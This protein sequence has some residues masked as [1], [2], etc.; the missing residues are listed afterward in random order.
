MIGSFIHKI[1][2]YLLRLAVVMAMLIISRAG[3]AQDD[4][5]I[6][7]VKDGNMFIWL[8]KKLPPA[9]LDAFIVKFDLGH[10]ALK[11]FIESG[12]T[13]SIKLA[14]WVVGLNNSSSF[15][16]AKPL[17]SFDGINDPAKRITFMGLEPPLDLQFPSVSNSVL[18]GYNKFRNKDPFAIKDSVVTFYLR[19]NRKAEKVMLA[20]SFNNWDPSAMSMTKTDSGWIAGVTLK[21]GK[22]WYKFIVDGKWMTDPDNGYTEN[23]YAGNTNSVYFFTNT[24]FRLAGYT[25]AKKVFVAGSFNG[26]QGYQLAM[27]K[28]ANSWELP[29]YLADGTHTYR[30]VVDGKWMTDP[31]NPVQYPNE[32]HETNAVIT[33]GTPHLF[34]LDGFSEAKTVIVTGSF[35]GWRKD[36]LYMKKTDRG[37]ELPYVLGKGNYEYKFI[38][39]GKWIADPANPPYGNNKE[40]NSLLVL[41]PNYTFRL[42]GYAGAQSVYLAGDFNNWNPSSMAMR[43]ENDDWVFSVYMSKGKHLYKF[44]V[45]GKWIIDP[46]NKLWEQNEHDSGNSVIWFNE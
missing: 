9:E 13:D 25:Q 18:F 15:T 4:I 11:R 38:V 14:G 35:N 10:L 44:I 24:V 8:S 34:T 43:K 29:V 41:S 40:A 7:T 6:C 23:D 46:D 42:K 2:R 36:E 39:D 31:A 3:T 37:W 26:W 21:P 32:Y 28:N 45:D 33:I 27:N 5:K 1:S 12:Y 30:F 20:G 17:E 16:L 22:Y 19:N